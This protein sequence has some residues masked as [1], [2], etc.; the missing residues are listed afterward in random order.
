MQYASLTNPA[1]NRR[2]KEGNI[3]AKKAP[4]ATVKK[5]P[6]R[7]QRTNFAI[8]FDNP[9]AEEELNTPNTR[10]SPWTPK[11]AEVINAVAE[12]RAKAGQW[13]KIA[14][15]GNSTGARTVIRSLLNNPH[16]VPGEIELQSR[17]VPRDG[18]KVSELYAS[19][20]A[21]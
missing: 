9:I 6:E 15:F 17:V 7:V 21:A 3:M 2:P 4:A 14:E 13:Y 20:P 1:N 19:V 11:L 10:P 18:R 8:D 5:R 12:G 16:R